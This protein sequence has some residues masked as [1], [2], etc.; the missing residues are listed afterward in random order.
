M[1]ECSPSRGMVVNFQNVEQ[2]DNRFYLFHFDQSGGRT[3]AIKQSY[4]VRKFNHAPVG[5]LLY[6]NIVCEMA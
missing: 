1:I 3:S 2:L 6:K 4:R 5:R